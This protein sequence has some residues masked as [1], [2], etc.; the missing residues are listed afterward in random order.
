[1]AA[2]SAIADSL[3]RQKLHFVDVDGTR[4]RYYED[5]AGEPLVL[6]HGGNF[7]SGYSLD[8]WSLNFS[9][10]AR[11]FRVYALDKLGQGH[12]DNPKDDDYTFD[13]VYR[14]FRGFLEAVGIRGMLGIPA[15]ARS[16]TPLARTTGDAGIYQFDA[17]F[18][19]PV[20]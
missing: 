5:G 4:T 1:M 14:H 15:G 20:P 12:T 6:V 18:K 11:H 10:L 16:A 7:G 9:T 17:V 2:T 19:R 3:D 8:C 13:A